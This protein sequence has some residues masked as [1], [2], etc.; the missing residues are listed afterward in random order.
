MSLPAETAEMLDLATVGYRRA[1]RFSWHFARGKLRGDPSFRNLLARGLLSG[2][3]RLLDLGCG[4][5]LLASWL[6]AARAC[7]GR[8]GAWPAAWPEPPTLSA[9][10]GIELSPSEVHRARAAFADR[11]DVQLNIVQGNITAVPFPA[12]DAVV[13]LDVLHYLDRAAQ[14]Q[15]LERVRACLPA[16]GLLLLRVGDTAGGFGF[17]LSQITDR[18]V[19]LCRR[20]R[21]LTLHCRPL[22]EW[23]GLLERIGFSSTA[24]P[25]S[26][27]T[28]FTNTL[29]VAEAR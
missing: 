14:E 20:G 9:Y 8:A 10:T 2:R 22:H 6:L 17:K 21:W 12:V 19:T 26:E 27:G 11:A 1:S 4:Q 16:G 13:I 28:P 25:M 3:A 15:V 7:Y 24:V 23:Q 29:L 18:L 5:G